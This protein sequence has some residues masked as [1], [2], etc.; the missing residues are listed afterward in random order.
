MET[1]NPK[2]ERLAEEVMHG[3]HEWREQH[4]KATYAEIESETMKRT[5]EMQAGLIE[6]MVQ[7]SEAADWEAAEAPTCPECGERMQKRGQQE[8]HL[9]SQGGAEVILRRAYAL[10]PVCGAELFPPG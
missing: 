5:A 2:W 6:E 10:C 3:M 1:R 8:R 7:M 4:P 9:Q